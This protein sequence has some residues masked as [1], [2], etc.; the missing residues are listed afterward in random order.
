MMKNNKLQTDDFLYT[1]CHVFFCDF[2]E[3]DPCIY[4]SHYDSL[5]AFIEGSLDAH[6]VSFCIMY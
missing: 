3:G 2:R 5:K 6:K 1:A 4:S